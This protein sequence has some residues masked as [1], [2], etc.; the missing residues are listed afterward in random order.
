MGYEGDIAAFV[1]EHADRWRSVDEV[2]DDVRA[3]GLDLAAVLDAIP[4]SPC[5]DLWERLCD[6]WEVDCI[7]ELLGVEEAAGVFSRTATYADLDLRR[8]LATSRLWRLVGAG[9]PLA[10]LATWIEEHGL[11]P[12]AGFWRFVCGRYELR[13]LVEAGV[14]PVEVL[15]PAL[16]GR[17]SPL[18]AARELE[19]QLGD[20]ELLRA[21]GTWCPWLP[22]GPVV[23]PVFV[24]D[25]LVRIHRQEDASLWAVVGIS[26]RRWPGLPEAERLAAL[27]RG[28]FSAG[29]AVLSLAEIGVGSPL[30]IVETLSVAGYPTGAIVAGLRGNAVGP[31]RAVE[32]LE[33]HGLD[34]AEIAGALVGQQLAPSQVRE[35][36]RLLGASDERIRDALGGLLAPDVMA[37]LL[38]GP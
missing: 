4:G 30:E 16:R 21:L 32:L 25:A 15:E 33:R 12:D 37:L 38:P 31:T 3:R 20:G 6:G 2:L 17:A 11:E 24:L 8:H 29:F 1:T 23:T 34:L 14:V 35:E 28:G 10:R 26:R 27:R 7:A 22:A 9:E 36:L 13:P 19:P 18:E 5:D